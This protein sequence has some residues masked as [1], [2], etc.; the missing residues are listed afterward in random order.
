MKVYDSF[1]FFNELDL[2]EIRLN[3]LAPVVDFF[4]ISESNLTFSGKTK[5]YYF[6]ENIERFSKFKSKIIHQKIEDNPSNFHHLELRKG[7]LGPKDLAYNKIIGWINSATNFPKDVPHWGRDFYQREC[8][9]LAYSG[10]DNDDLIVFSDVDEIPNPET[11]KNVLKKFPSFK[12]YTLRQAEFNFYLNAYK[13]GDWRGPRVAEYR[14]LKNQSLNKIRT[15]LEGDQTIVPAIDVDNGGWHF[16]SLGDAEKVIQKIES[17][18]H[19]EY[20][21]EEIKLKVA[22]NIRAGKDAFERE[23]EPP[24]RMVKIDERIFPKWLVD[25]QETYQRHILKKSYPF[26]FRYHTKRIVRFLIDKIKLVI[27]HDRQKNQ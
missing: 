16:T 18:G 17:W 4:I 13:K 23:G 25:N 1:L 14:T 15:I 11:L 22:E 5:P 21:T 6:L 2:L 12:I 7:D 9:H 24:L 8:L 26:P 19:Q 20:N 10:L 3:L 27:K